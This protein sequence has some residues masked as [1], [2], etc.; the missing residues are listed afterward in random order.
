MAHQFD[1]KA[2]KQISLFIS[3]FSKSGNP[4]KLATLGKELSELKNNFITKLHK[5][6]IKQF[7]KQF[8]TRLENEFQIELRKYVDK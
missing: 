3:E 4:R 7:D 5:D 2:R 8:L 6:N 1:L